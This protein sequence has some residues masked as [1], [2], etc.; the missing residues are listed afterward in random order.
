[1]QLPSRNP[2]RLYAELT[3]LAKAD[4]DIVRAAWRHA[5]AGRNVQPVG[6]NLICSLK[7][8]IG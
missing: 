7:A 8:A 5:E 4:E 6:S 3:F 1:M 2:Q